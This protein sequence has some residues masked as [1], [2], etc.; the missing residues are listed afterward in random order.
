MGRMDG[1]PGVPALTSVSVKAVSAAAAT[2]AEHAAPG[3]YLP[4]PHSLCSSWHHCW[5]ESKACTANHT[6]HSSRCVATM[7]RYP[8]DIL[9]Q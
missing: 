5:V 8:S 6:P 4:A 2:T 7:C 1:R 3:Q 9:L